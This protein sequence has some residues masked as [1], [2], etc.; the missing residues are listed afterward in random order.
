[1]SC[2][3]EEAVG[4]ADPVSVGVEL[5]L[6]SQRGSLAITM[7]RVA[8]RPDSW[9]CSTSTIHLPPDAAAD[10]AQSIITLGERLRH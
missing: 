9:Y 3:L 6:T 2:V 5:Q 10:L 8:S 1:M 4:D 7:R